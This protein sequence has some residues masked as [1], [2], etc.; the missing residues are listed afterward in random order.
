MSE[1]G[2]K[3]GFETL[4]RRLTFNRKL[5]LFVHIMVAIFSSFY[6]LSKVDLPHFSF[7]RGRSSLI[8]VLMALPAIIPYAGSAIYSR[9]VV[10]YRRARTFIFLLILIAGAV[11]I[12]LS[13]YNHWIKGTGIL[14]W[15]GV[16]TGV[17]L[18]AAELLLNVV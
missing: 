11:L 15:V 7:T 4:Y 9:Q 18:W 2:N 14:L 10:T 8:V 17:Y 5:L 3:P 1:S 6:F 12:N 13:L 16:Q